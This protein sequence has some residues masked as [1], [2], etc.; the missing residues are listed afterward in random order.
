MKTREPKRHTGR[1]WQVAAVLAAGILVA[2][3]SAAAQGTAPIPA[4][5]PGSAD[6]NIFYG[7]TPQYAENAPVLVFVHGLKGRA[8]DW[9]VDNDMFDAVYRWGY[10]SAYVSLNVDNTPNDAT[11]TANVAVLRTVLP[12]IR[13]HFGVTQMYLIGHSKG[14]VDLQGAMLDPLMRAMTRAIFT[15]S[16]PNQGTE[17]AD[18]AFE[19]PNL[20]EP[21][22]LLT[23]GV[24]VLKTNNMAIFR[25]VLDPVLKA[26]GIPI[27]SVAGS[28]FTGN[29]LTMVTGT[30][31][32]GL[33]PGPNDGYVTVE[34]SKLPASYGIDLG[35]IPIHHFQTDSGNQVFARINSRIDGF[36]R[37]LVVFD[38]IAKDGM[39]AIG[40]SR[41]NTWAWSMAWYKGHLYLG[42]GREVTCV[43]VLSG[44]VENGTNVYPFT[45]SQG[46]CPPTDVLPAVLGAEIWRH[47]PVTRLWTR[48]FRSP[49]TLQVGVDSTGAPIFTSRD[50]GFR[51]M[52]V[53]TEANGEEALYVGGVTSGSIYDR[54]PP[55]DTQGYPPPRLLRSVNGLDFEP[56]PQAPGTF[57]G[58]IGNGTLDSPQKFRSFRSMRAFNGRLY[59]TMADYLGVGIIIVSSDPSAGDNSWSQVSPSYAEFPVWA[60]Y[61][62]NGWLYATTGKTMLQDPSKPGY[63]VYKTDGSSGPAGWIPVVT[64]GGYQDEVAVRSPNGLSFGELN[65]QLY[66]GMNRPTELI[67]LNADDSWDLIVGEPRQTP[68]GYK[69]PLSGF[70]IGFGSWFNGH[71]W[72]MA[73]FEGQLHL[74]T[75]DWSIGVIGFKNLDKP[76]ASQY[77]FNFL[78]TRDGIHWSVLSDVGL[79]DPYDFG[80]RTL[81]VT[82]A[83]FFVGTTRPLGGFT[84]YKI[85]GDR[86]AALPAPQ[87]DAA[88]E[89]SVGRTVALSWTPVPDAVR[90][91]VY[92][93]EVRPAPELFGLPPVDPVP[94]DS[95]PLPYA[96][97]AVTTT[98]SFEQPA[99]T[100]M[101]SIYFVRAEN[102]Q[103]Q[104]SPPS[105][106]VGAPS[107]A[108]PAAS[109][110]R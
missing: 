65:G 32:Q 72:R 11:V 5:V 48:V 80:G 16:A 14:G 33:A 37:T 85:N 53:F 7:G 24:F 76:F 9:W 110:V 55:Y 77:G 68:T 96:F 75:W 19:N 94:P 28:R 36:E 84:I 97:I 22:G 95:F 43:S 17:L 54:T 47:D 18:W 91:R 99:P 63:G 59:A 107:K 69:A 30:V 44:D 83:G 31:L 78:R 4:P 39:S 98:T 15:I 50:A 62:W 45:V 90:Y 88:S 10:R 101:Q 56:V 64:S 42:T 12:K 2:A 51:G 104:L 109:L 6:Q 40:G 27:Y 67:R 82:P 61:P 71:F 1:C 52:T 57:L 66:V 108:A 49:D 58:D 81:E 23:P 21:L 86:P 35:T 20:A 46:Q 38:R 105:N 60:L 103:G 100:V 41:H 89:Q 73:T 29:P 25:Q 3:G 87:V 102:A 34:R 13:Q 93:A 26:S 74:S 70:G 8:Q 92:R 79:G 106:I